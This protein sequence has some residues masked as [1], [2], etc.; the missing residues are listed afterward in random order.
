MGCGNF[1]GI[2]KCLPAVHLKKNDARD[3]ADDREEADPVTRATPGVLLF[4]ITEIAFV[5]LGNLFLC[6]ARRGHGRRSIIKKGHERMPRRE[7]Q[8]QK[9]ERHVHK[10]PGVQPM[11]QFRLQIEHAA[12]VAP[13]LDF[14]HPAAIRFG[15]AQFCETER[16]VRKARVVELEFFAAARAE[17]R[18]NLPLD[19]LDQRRF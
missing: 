10:K 16:V 9:G 12:L 4:V 1:P 2:E 8:E 11:V 7:H 14:F 5:A 18:K 3:P 15:H 17:I 19:K 6:S 13:R